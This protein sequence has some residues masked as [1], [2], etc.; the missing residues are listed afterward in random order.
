MR[1]LPRSPLY[2]AAAAV[3][4]AGILLLTATPASAQADL[5]DWATGAGSGLDQIPCEPP[6]TPGEPMH[7]APW[8]VDASGLE[9]AHQ[10]NQGLDGEG[11]PVKVAVIDSG[12]N[13]DH[14][15]FNG[16]VLPGGDPYDPDSDAQC[17]LAGHGTQ[18]AAI[19]AGG[20]DDVG[21]MGVAPKA[22]IIPFRVYPIGDEGGNDPERSRHIAS[23]INA[24]VA[25][26]AQVINISIAV[27]HTAELEA[28]VDNAWEN[29]VLIVAAT[30]NESLWMD[31]E[32]N[33]L[34]PKDEVY[35]P[36]NYEKTI[37]VGAYNRIGNLFGQE[38]FGPNLDLIAPG[39]EIT[40]PSPSGEG[41]VPSVQGTSFAAPHVAGAAALLI[42]EFGSTVATPQWI[43]D[44][45]IATAT[46]PPDKW[47]QYQGHGL[48]NIPK[49]LT[50]SYDLGD[51]KTA[52]PVDVEPRQLEPLAINQDPLATEK[53]IAWSSLGGAIALII[54][55][56][57]LKKVIPQG[58]RRRWRPGTRDADR[59]PV[60]AE[61]ESI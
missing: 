19:I 44:R 35:Y 59:L 60:K 3:A 31:N 36:A 33:R 2:T 37:A 43:T 15:T 21:F 30:G 46:P 12:T 4:T 50:A 34:E 47:N 53:T 27:M 51:E 58:R 39:V 28:A 23:T 45:L 26:G 18:V 5:R 40:V 32:N 13:A 8:H 61:G 17:D 16:N 22:Q 52:A 48:L 24:A 14:P 6:D 42:G 29:N 56:L 38:N 54:L 41:Y 10:Y 11:Q 55:V 49:A 1:F 9:L 7:G 57:V 25:A 20:H